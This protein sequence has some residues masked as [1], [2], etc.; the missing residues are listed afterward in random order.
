[1]RTTIGLICFLTVFVALEPKLFADEEVVSYLKVQCEE[2][3]CAYHCPGGLPPGE[4]CVMTYTYVYDCT[5]KP[6]CPY[7]TSTSTHFYSGETNYIPDT[8]ISAS[9]AIVQ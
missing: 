8:A 5:T 2:G 4:H 6:P 1:M 9:A 3:V 7:V